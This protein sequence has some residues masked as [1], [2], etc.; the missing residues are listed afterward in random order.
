LLKATKTAEMAWW[1]T[2]ETCQK[3]MMELVIVVRPI[4]QMR[5]YPDDFAVQLENEN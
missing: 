4:P 5:S 1:P 2:C 3:L